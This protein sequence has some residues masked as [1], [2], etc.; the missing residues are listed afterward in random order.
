MIEVGRRNAACDELFNTFPNV[1]W[2]FS[3][4]ICLNSR[5]SSYAFIPLGFPNEASVST[6]RSSRS[7]GKRSSATKRFF[8]FLIRFH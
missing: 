2:N 3:I 8:D 1:Y 6:R 4:T 5:Y 7:N